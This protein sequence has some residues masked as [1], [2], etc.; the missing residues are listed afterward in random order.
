MIQHSLE[1]L[2]IRKNKTL[3]FSHL[4]LVLPLKRIGRGNQQIGNWIM[5]VWELLFDCYGIAHA[6]LTLQW[7]TDH[8]V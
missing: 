1:R 3:H 2:D 7:P 6:P 8:Q 4:G 5:T